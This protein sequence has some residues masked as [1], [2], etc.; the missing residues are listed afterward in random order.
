MLENEEMKKIHLILKEKG[1][2]LNMIPLMT[3]IAL[4]SLEKHEKDEL[5]FDVIISL[6]DFIT[7]LNDVSVDLTKQL[8]GMK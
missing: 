1:F 7:I 4:K 6:R 3:M 5:Y 8:E 2:A